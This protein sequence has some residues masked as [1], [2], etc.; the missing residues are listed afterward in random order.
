MSRY[1]KVDPKIWNDEKFRSLSD[2]SQLVF[3]Y[4]LTHPHQTSLGAMRSSVPGLAAEKQWKLTRF[5]RAFGEIQTKG[6]VRLDH[7]ASLLWLPN[8]LKYNGPE[9]PNVVKSWSQ[10][11]DLLPECQLK[12]NIVEHVK[13]FLETLPKAFSEAL[14][15]AFA[16][17]M[18]NQEQELEQEQNK[19]GG[20]PPARSGNQ[21]AKD[22][23][24]NQ[25]LD[26]YSENFKT[27]FGKPPVINRG[28]DSATFKR[29]LETYSSD[30]LKNMLRE[31]FESD[32]KFVNSAGRTIGVFS[33]CINKF[34]S[35]GKNAPRRFVG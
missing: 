30:Q 26:F 13:I 33:S 31:F 10:S 17:S 15:E 7:R 21:E 34:L 8:F 19:N 6:M 1:R 16:K 32:D 20:E 29:L 25:L 11:L 23:R 18:P 22:G 5:A 4:L 2:D 35:T 9:S 14:P 28:K 27:N 3:F 24:V 12:S